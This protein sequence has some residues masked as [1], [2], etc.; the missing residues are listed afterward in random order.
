MVVDFQK[1]HDLHAPLTINDTT[2]ERVLSIL[3][4][5][6][7]ITENLSCCENIASL[8]I[9]GQQCLYFLHKIRQA[10]IFFTMCTFYRENIDSLLSSCINVWSGA[11]TISCCKSLQH[12]V[13][14]AEKVIGAPLSIIEDIYSSSLTR[15]ALKSQLI[16]LIHITVSLGCCFQEEDY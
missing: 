12:I 7:H 8:V 4:L 2:V 6:V 1:A 3:F 5:G 10:T 14:T 13:R 9:R 11:S 15:K 16:S